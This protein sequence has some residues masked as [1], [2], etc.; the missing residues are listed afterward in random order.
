[1]SCFY[2][3]YFKF[4]WMKFFRL[5]RGLCFTGSLS[6][7]AAAAQAQAPAQTP[8][9]HSPANQQTGKLFGRLVDGKGQP[10]AYATITLLRADSSVVNG[11]LTKDNGSF[12]IEPTGSGKFHLRISAIGFQQK[13]VD[14]VMTPDNPE[15]DLGK[16]TVSASATQLKEVQVTGER[17]VV[18]MSVDKKTFNVE[19]NITT[20][21]G[22]ASDVLQNVPSVS[23]DVDGNVALRGKGDV[24][25][26]I[27]GKPATLLG[28]DA[29]SALQSL[30]ASSIQSVE[31]IT[32]P[33]SKYDAQGMTG[34]I[35]IVTKRDA[36]FGLNGTAS[37][38]A[39]TRD[40]YNGALNLNLRNKKW[41]LTANSS[42]RLNS[43][44]NRTTST[45]QMKATDTAS[46]S[47]EDN[48]RK[49]NGWF[50]TL[51]AEY[52]IDNNNTIGL[53]ENINLMHFG[54][55]GPTNY[56]V[57]QQPESLVF[58]QN[59]YTDRS[60]GPF[61]VS[62][63]LDYKHKFHKEKRELTAN[64]TFS[65]SWMTM[66][67][68]YITDTFDHNEAI[69]SGPYIQ[70]AP[71]SG[72]NSTF[73]AQVDY[74]T[75]F[76]TKNGKLDAGL[77]SQLFWFESSNNPT[78]TDP[79]GNTTVDYTLLNGYNYSQK[80]YAAYASFSDQFGKFS[81]QAGLRFEDATYE[82]T[83]TQA[84][85]QHY[86]NDF[87]NLFPT[88]FLS[89]KLKQDQ[90]V[91]L[92]Y[93]RRTNR[94]DFRQLMPYLDLSN[95]QDTS[96]GNPNLKPE[97]INN[98]EL[99]YN[100]QFKQGH[101]IIV[102]AYYQYTENLIQKYTRYNPDF[103]TFTMPMNLNSGTTYGLEAI[104]KVQI[105]PIWDAT[106]NFNFFQNEIQGS[107]IDPSLDNSG[108]SW[109][110]KINT[111]VKL[112]AGFSLQLNGNYE[113]P[114]I[115]GQGNLQEAWWVDA[116]I[117]K[118]FWGGKANVVFNV[119]DIF[120]TRKYT[121]IYDLTSYYQ[122]TYRDRETRVGNIT[123]TWRFGK[124]DMKGGGRKKPSQSQPQTKERDNL[125]GDDSDQ[126][127]GGF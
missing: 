13:F 15:K 73:N 102:S 44:Y 19:K 1:M 64:A 55:T 60:G 10:I 24:T 125:K 123:F 37:L 8:Q 87:P 6:L 97:F 94:P 30:P 26:L 47:F 3:L 71:S 104:G 110:G 31:V 65:K 61:S 27:D 2:H 126:G 62:S 111:N 117:R 88:I 29:V 77:K 115:S 69:I 72:S 108:F 56:Q 58:G 66:K 68:N 99:S 122:N 43:N 75:P 38:G 4:F 46:R 119:S 116:A 95:P 25:I 59:R 21:G 51:A 34:I 70:N 50:N 52:T 45:L 76:L 63:A 17:P 89:Y 22:S 80:T 93:T 103:T 9:T 124:S 83:V 98:V 118:N 105:M 112:P 14:V 20:A 127:G 106:I 92:S 74:T 54:G 40:K 78:I 28:G 35:N 11:D 120:N 96:S 81:Y 82:G 32:N 57:F 91:Y 86:S 18:E 85:G 90:S 48:Q 33:S 109:L 79:A 100:K 113:S 41:N 12:T 67:Q 101:N 16:V 49:F 42:F 121:T 39:G 36:K 114:K 107:N 84:N 5:F 23:V 7:L 53:T